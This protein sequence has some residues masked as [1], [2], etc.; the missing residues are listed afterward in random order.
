MSHHY[1]P[2][3]PGLPPSPS[4]ISHAVVAGAHCYISGQLATNDAGAFRPGSAR[5]EAELAFRNVF[6]ALQAAGFSRDDLVFI[7]L[8]LADIEELGEVNALFAELFPEGGRPAR[9]VHQAAALPYGGRIKVQAVAIAIQKDL[10]AA[11]FS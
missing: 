5:E 11:D 10:Y 2:G 8:A 1:V 7:D 4:P 3:A 6:A 9:T